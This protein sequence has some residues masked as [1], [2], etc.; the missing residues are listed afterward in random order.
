MQLRRYYFSNWN[1]HLLHSTFAFTAPNCWNFVVLGAH[2]RVTLERQSLLN[3]EETR[4]LF[5]TMTPSSFDWVLSCFSL[6]C[7]CFSRCSH[8]VFSSPE[9]L[10]VWLNPLSNIS[11]I[12]VAWGV[13]RL[14]V[15]SLQFALQSTSI[16]CLFFIKHVLVCIETYLQVA[17]TSWVLFTICLTNSREVTYLPYLRVL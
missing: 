7:L 5:S 3:V 16:D 6:S 1:S 10:T 12:F 13:L 9:Y 14:T 11:Q 17:W 2:L 4:V 8:A 15:E